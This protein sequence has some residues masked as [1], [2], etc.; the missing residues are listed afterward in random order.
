METTACRAPDKALL[1]D[2]SVSIREVLVLES[3]R[4]FRDLYSGEVSG[5]IAR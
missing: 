1:S 3:E 4:P 5:T 2:A